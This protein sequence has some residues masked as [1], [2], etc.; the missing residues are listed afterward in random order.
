MLDATYL[1]PGVYLDLSDARY[2]ADP[3]P[4]P[5]LSSTIARVLLDQSPRHAWFAHPRL[6]PDHQSR[7]SKTFD[8][9]RAIHRAVLG[10]GG[11]YVAYPPEMLAANGAASTKAA[12]EWADEQ[13]AMGCTPLKAEEVDVIGAAADAVTARLAAMGIHLDPARSEV[14]AFAEIDG[15]F[16]RCRVDNA[17][18]DPRLPLIDIKSTTDASTDA[19]IASIARYGY[20]VQAAH[21][22]DTWEAATGERRRFRF[23]FIEKE[24]PHEVAVVEL[25]DHEAAVRAGRATEGNEESLASDWMLDARSKA[26]EARRIWGECLAADQWPGYPAQVAVVGAPSWHSKKWADR[27]I[28]R[29]VIAQKP[30]A[31]SLAAAAAWQQP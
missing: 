20:D 21:Y 23:V 30:T 8:I 2:H 14:S 5:S 13:R 31:Q 26:R 15:I 27:E 16:C 28:G 25:Y 4:A 29:P 1:G 11:D 17:P 10:K 18:A 9:G 19:V 24:P 7:G 12:K 22:L 3:A 6:N